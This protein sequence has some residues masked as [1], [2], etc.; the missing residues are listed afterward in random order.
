MTR[1]TVI[2]AG[3]VAGGMVL[4]GQAQAR[5][6]GPWRGGVWLNR[7]RKSIITA[8]ALEMTTDKGSD[9]WRE[10]FY[11]FTRDSGH[12]YGM[13]APSRFTAQLRIRAEYE[14]LYDQAGLM[15]RIDEEHWVK[16]GIELSDGRAM[17]SSVL[18]DGRSDWATAPYEG[19]PKDF[20]MRATV[21][22]GV[23]RLQVS[24]DGRTWPLVR[25]APFPQA[26]SY[27]VGPMCCT[28]E[29]QGL[30]VRFSDWKLGAP[31]GKALH[32]LT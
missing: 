11:G 24:A 21:A 29:R 17:L 14:K 1:R 27:L 8:D 16:A 9:F 32:D 18:T 25:L 12:F 10:T 3:T 26:G 19:D 5:A 22:D 2:A 15:V 30:K 4:G 23:L 7:P 20:W 6:P 28:P 31:L 13:H